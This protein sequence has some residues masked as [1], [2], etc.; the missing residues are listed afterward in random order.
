MEK[1][2]MVSKMEDRNFLGLLII[3]AVLALAGGCVIGG[4]LMSLAR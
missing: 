4:S 3:L 2:K 1:E